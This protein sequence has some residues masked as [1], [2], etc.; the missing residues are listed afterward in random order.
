MV[1]ETLAEAIID[2]HAFG[3][4]KELPVMVVKQHDQPLFGL[5]WCLEFDIYMP[6]R[7]TIC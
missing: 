4:R 2:V 3:M 5:D 6:K 7:V 1:I